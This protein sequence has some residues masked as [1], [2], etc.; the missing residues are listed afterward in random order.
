MAETNEKADNSVKW[1]A[2]GCTS[3]TLRIFLTV[4]TWNQLSGPI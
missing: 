2:T 3:W 4:T 1:R